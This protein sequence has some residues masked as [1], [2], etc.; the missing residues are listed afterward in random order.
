[1]TVNKLPD[2]LAHIQQAANEAC[3]FISNLSKDEFFS[4]RRT[5]NAVVMSLIVIGEASAKVMDIYADFALS[6]PSVPWRKMRGMR[7]R[8]TH[9][10]FEVDFYMVWDTVTLALPELLQQ[11]SSV[12]DAA[13]AENQNASG[14]DP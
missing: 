3:G 4:D 5:Q 1:M 13:K 6:H 8:I 9:G 2:Y 11:L 12:Q 7:N 10:Y 14:V